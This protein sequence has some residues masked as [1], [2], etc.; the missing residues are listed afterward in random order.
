MWIYSS[1]SLA[2]ADKP[3]QS[4]IDSSSR[5]LL[6][7]TFESRDEPR[8]D[9][10]RSSSS[11]SLDRRRNELTSSRMSKMVSDLPTAI[12]QQQQHGTRSH[13]KQRSPSMTTMRTNAHDDLSSIT[14][15]VKQDRPPPPSSGASR[16]SLPGFGG[17]GDDVS[18]A[19]PAKDDAS[20]LIPG[21]GADVEDEDEF[22]YG[23]DG[24]SI[25]SKNKTTPGGN[26]HQRVTDCC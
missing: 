25:S 18:S 4:A 1:A 3:V 14:R 15:V 26:H 21:I 5:E 17:G 20:L 10:A 22:L 12:D 11:S 9:S 7:A 13:S 8:P 2:A 6:Y 19:A 16:S 23:G 24:D